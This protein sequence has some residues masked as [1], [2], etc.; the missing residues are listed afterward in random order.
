MRVLLD[1]N[2]VLKRYVAEPGSDAVEAV[3][4]AA[5]AG[6]AQLVY[7]L[8]T[9]GECLGVLDRLERQGRLPPG[10]LRKGRRA[11]TG[12]SARLARLGVLTITPLGARL[13]RKAWT[14]LL[15]HHL[16]QADALQIASAVQH[17]VDLLLTSDQQVA[18]A[19]RAEGLRVV[20]PETD[21]AEI[22]R[23]LAA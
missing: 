22:A 8:W 23:A 14:L 11:L 7:S 4:R 19:A 20:D 18:E 6:T 5:D 1:A 10:G 15:R 13:V 21:G 3:Y 9:L 16:Y 2:A 17:K 12:E